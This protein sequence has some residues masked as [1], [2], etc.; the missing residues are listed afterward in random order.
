MKVI[1][2]HSV[3]GDGAVA[4]LYIEDGYI[5]EKVKYPI[6]K[7]AEPAKAFVNKAIDTL[8]EKIPGDW[9]KLI[10]EPGR[11]AALAEIDKLVAG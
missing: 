8:E 6:A 4:G 3:G 10:L 2:E 9:D 11:A 5:V 1:Y 7:A